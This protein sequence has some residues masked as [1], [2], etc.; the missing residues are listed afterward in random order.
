MGRNKYSKQWVIVLLSAGLLCL[1]ILGVQGRGER[2]EAVAER[3]PD[4]EKGYDLPVNE[5]DAEE[6]KE[7]GMQMMEKIKNAVITEKTAFPIL[8]DN[9]YESVRNYERVDEFLRNAENG[10]QGEIVIYEVHDDGGLGR[11]KFTFDGE[12]MYVLH[13]GFMWNEKNEPVSYGTTYTR[14]KE[15]EYTEKGWFCYEYCVPEPP[16]VTEVV[17]G[18]CMMRI[19]PMDENLR[20]ISEKYLRPIGYSGNN[21]LCS[22]WEAEHIESLDYSGLFEYF[23]FMKHQ[24]KVDAETYLGG[25]GKQ[26]FEGL[27]TEYLEITPEQLQKYAAY[28]E[29][30]QTYG[31]NRLG[32][33]NFT[34]R[35]FDL[36]IPEAVQ[37]KE[38]ADGTMVITVDAVCE[39]LGNDCVISHELTI[40][41][42]EDGSVK[43]LSNKILGNGLEK[44][45]AYQ[46]RLR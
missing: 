42:Q 40:F 28:D 21:F 20:E 18:N 19:K 2:E 13:T 3:T 39:T 14:I 4:L 32:G 31:W 1:V 11:N 10:K 23:Y 24:K 5:K 22:D 38:N 45:P 33:G 9:G 36:S 15:W 35:G 26:E 7:E 6:A 37:V 41:P 27:M 25:I 46:Y 12:E 34:P 44:I 29:Q 30:T 16:E 43:Y 8:Y 17:D